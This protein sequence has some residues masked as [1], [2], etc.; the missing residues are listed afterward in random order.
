MAGR[1]SDGRAAPGSDDEGCCLVKFKDA[2]A[3]IWQAVASSLR[4]GM[5]G[6]LSAGGQS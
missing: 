1:R 6:R 5:E 4:D 3:G 2:R